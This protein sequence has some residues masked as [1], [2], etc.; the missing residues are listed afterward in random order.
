[1]PEGPKPIL[2]QPHIEPTAHPFNQVATI[3][4]RPTSPVPQHVPSAQ[5][6]QPTSPVPEYDPWAHPQQES[7][8]GIED[9]MEFCEPCES[10]SPPKDN[11]T[12]SI[13]DLV[14]PNGRN[15]T[16]SRVGSSPFSIAMPKKALNDT[17]PV[18]NPCLTETLSPPQLQSPNPK[19]RTGGQISGMSAAEGEPYIEPP[20]RRLTTPAPTSIPEATSA[21]QEPVRTAQPQ[22]TVVQE[23]P[24]PT[25]PKKPLPKGPN[26]LT[27]AEI[28]KC[29]EK[30]PVKRWW[31][32]YTDH[33]V[34]KGE[35][36]A[37]VCRKRTWD[38][39]HKKDWPTEEERLERNPIDCSLDKV[40]L[41][42]W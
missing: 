8:L 1:M 36:A 10:Y 39:K 40:G 15:W 7:L 19:T 29:Q 42:K 20:P 35:Q 33:D 31:N 22:P 4:P 17:P 24:K 41:Q 9:L 32:S 25:E 21:S 14:D 26:D 27:E 3:Q 12:T 13:L 23:P 6:K 11:R 2:A 38:D 34:K 16:S 37:C 28:A 18:E 5:A 30:V